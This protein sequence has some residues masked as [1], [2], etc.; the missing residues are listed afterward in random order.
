MKKLFMF[1]VSAA[2]ITQAYA[3]NGDDFENDGFAAWRRSQAAK[4]EN[5]SILKVENQS[6]K[7]IRVGALLS[8]FDDAPSAWGLPSRYFSI[9]VTP[10]HTEGYQRHLLGREWR[11]E[12]VR[13]NEIN[14]QSVSFDRKRLEPRQRIDIGDTFTVTDEMLKEAN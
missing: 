13:L 6:T 2:F 10:G 14:I 9:E 3:M 8:G 4:P 1:L 11:S 7:T 12:V 5:Q